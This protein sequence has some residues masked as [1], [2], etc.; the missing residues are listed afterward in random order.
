M[1][2]MVAALYKQDKIIKK[3]SVLNGHGRANSENY[4]PE[5]DGGEQTE[6]QEPVAELYKKIQHGGDIPIRGLQKPAPEKTKR[7]SEV[8][9]VSALGDT[10]YIS[11]PPPLA[12]A[13]A[14]GGVNS[15]GM[16]LCDARTTL[17]GLTQLS[18]TCPDD[19]KVLALRLC[20]LTAAAGVRVR[21]SPGSDAVLGRAPWVLPDFIQTSMRES[22]RSETQFTWPCVASHTGERSIKHA[23]YR[24]RKL[25]QTLPAAGPGRDRRVGVSAGRSMLAR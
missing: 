11:S 15:A 16:L 7:C 17:S 5:A 21:G 3:L 14:P 13:P 24:S 2:Q 4:R 19:R 25:D 10:E 18:L 12:A 6:N 23:R 22:L 20:G 9:P 1:D 8:E